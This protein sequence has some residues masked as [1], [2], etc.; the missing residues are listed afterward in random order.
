MIRPIYFSFGVTLLNINLFSCSSNYNFRI[1]E[2]LS[3]LSTELSLS[4]NV[5]AAGKVVGIKL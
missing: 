1:L 4:V 2:D 3:F 5:L